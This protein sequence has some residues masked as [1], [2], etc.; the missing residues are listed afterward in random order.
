MQIADRFFAVCIAAALSIFPSMVF[1]QVQAAPACVIVFGHGRNFEQGQDAHNQAWDGLNLRFN[2]QVLRSLELAGGRGFAMVLKS[3]AS[4]LAHNLGLL[5][6][7]V[8]AQGCSQVL[9]TTLFFDGSTQTLKARLRLYPVLGAKGPR[10]AGADL[11]IGEP[12]YTHERDFEFTRR[13]LERLNP[14]ALAQTMTEESMPQLLQG[15]SAAP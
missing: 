12:L 4:D 6:A 9:E 13:V 10:V 15:G 3:A 7:E 8:S 14:V 1:A 5:L 2:S 11:R